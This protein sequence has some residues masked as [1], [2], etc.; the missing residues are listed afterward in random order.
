MTTVVVSQRLHSSLPASRPRRPPGF[1]DKRGNES[2][3]TPQGSMASTPVFI[4]A[5]VCTSFVGPSSNPRNYQDHFQELVQSLANSPLPLDATLV[6]NMAS[7]ELLEWLKVKKQLKAMKGGKALWSVAN[8]EGDR[9]REGEFPRIGA[10]EIFVLSSN[11]TPKGTQVIVQEVYTKLHNGRWPTV[12][13]LASKICKA[14]GRI[15]KRENLAPRCTTIFLDPVGKLFDVH[16]H[17][18]GGSGKLYIPSFK[19]WVHP[20][21]EGELLSGFYKPDNV[22]EAM[23]LCDITPG[24]RVRSVNLRGCDIKFSACK[25]LATWVAKAQS[26]QTLNLRDNDIDAMGA[27]CIAE[28]LAANPNVV[29]VDLRNNRIGPKG[30]TSFA[31]MLRTN[32]SIL[33][34]NLYSNHLESEGGEVIAKALKRNYSLTTLDLGDN[35]LGDV[36]STKIAEALRGTTSLTSLQM[37]PLN[38]LHPGTS[39]MGDPRRASGSVALVN[40]LKRNPVMHTLNVGANSILSQ[41]DQDAERFPHKM[42]MPSLWKGKTTNNVP[43]SALTGGSLSCTRTKLLERPNDL[44][45]SLV[46]LDKEELVDTGPLPAWEYT[47]KRKAMFK[48]PT[49]PLFNQINAV[50]QMSLASLGQQGPRFGDALSY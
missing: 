24:M 1:G 21:V 11:V 34:L 26:L 33:Q 18:G 48:K 49:G 8:L 30:A 3:P 12:P 44:R 20:E 9:H 29:N 43:A 19:C 38:D 7:V 13:L 32:S 47:A 27:K 46:R 10:F 31:D 5:E 17:P 36:S 45:H 35:R 37:Q 42:L 50:H 28:A 22:S 15:K 6:Q 4:V 16:S 23:Q 25:E 2:S 41:W 39:G 14:I 40:T